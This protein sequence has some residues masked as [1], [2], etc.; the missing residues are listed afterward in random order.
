MPRRATRSDSSPGDAALSYEQLVE[1]LQAIVARLEGG[2]VSL[3]E[4]LRAYEEGIT[5]A[6]Q[7]QRILDSAEQ[8]IQELREAGGE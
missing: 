5:L 6:A 4:A 7:C 3:E 2:G 1:R 8:R